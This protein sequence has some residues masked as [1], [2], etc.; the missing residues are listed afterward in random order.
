MAF[1]R[2]KSDRVQFAHQHTVNL[3]AVDGTWS[4]VCVLKDISATGA[5]LEVEGSTDVLTSRE[6][7]LV[8]SSTGLA[9]RRCQLVWVDGPTAGVHFIH[10][11]KKSAS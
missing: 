5:K 10:D 7:F 3:M 8:L 1:G 9:F 2:R 11:K 6:F 4:R